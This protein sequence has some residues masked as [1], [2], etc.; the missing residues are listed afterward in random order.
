MQN[1]ATEKTSSGLTVN[2]D[3]TQS[4]NEHNASKSNESGSE[5]WTVYPSRMF[6]SPW[7]LQLLNFAL[8]TRL[9]LSTLENTIVGT[10]LV[11]IMNDLEGFNKSS[12]MANAYLLT[13]TAFLII[14][15]KMS[16]IFGRRTMASVSLVYLHHCVL[17]LRICADDDSTRPLGALALLFIYIAI[18]STF[19][20]ANP[21]EAPHLSKKAFLR[22]E[23]LGTFLLLAASALLLTTLEEGGIGSSWSS[24]LVLSTLI[25]S[26]FF[27]TSF[28]LWSKFQASRSTLQEPILP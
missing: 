22:L 25:T 14:T 11:P 6:L 9:F 19:P 17:G 8:C 12:W 10:A 27:W 28:I 3:T 16:D 4:K 13:Y 23:I 2:V 18:P 7:K 24:P 26:L 15:A 20:Y 5:I 1:T 21:S